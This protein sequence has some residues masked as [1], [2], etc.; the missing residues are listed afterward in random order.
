MIA[1]TALAAT[2]GVTTPCFDAPAPKR[3]QPTSVAETGLALSML[4]DL[5][6]KTIHFAGRP[7]GK[8]LANQLALSYPVTEELLTFLRQGQAIEIVGTSATLQ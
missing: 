3:P 1:E 5:M 7:S 4:A 6:L 2:N 8:Y